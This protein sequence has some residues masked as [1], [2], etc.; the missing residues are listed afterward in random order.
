MPDPTSSSS[1]TRRLH[2]LTLA[3]GLLPLATLS[4]DAH[5]DLALATSKNCMGCHAL[6]KKLIGP[7][8][9]E[10]AAKYKGRKDAE[11]LLTDKVLKGSSGV[12]GTVAMP[13]ATNVSEAEAK[14]LV[15]WVL[16][17]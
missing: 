6:N 9:S 7:A 8:Y 15:A 10:I 4:L 12:W 16:S 17:Q 3:L 14:K 1:P 11:S 5:A 2:P 13:P